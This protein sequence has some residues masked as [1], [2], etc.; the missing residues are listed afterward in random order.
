MSTAHH[1]Q[2]GSMP[3][4]V[5]ILLVL[6]IA[7]LLTV[8]L[9]AFGQSNSAVQTPDEGERVFNQVCATCHQL[10]PPASMEDG[11]PIAPPM[12]MILRHYQMAFDSTSAMEVA[13]TSWLEKPDAE[14]SVLPAH[15]VEEHGLMPPLTITETERQAVVGYLMKMSEDL[16]SEGMGGKMNHDM[17]GMQNGQGK[18]N[19]DMNGMQNGQ[20][21]MNHK[22]MD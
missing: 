4:V 8:L 20:G 15:A 16:G 17:N 5:R 2:N 12:K 3:G 7:F 14:R 13:L 19:H 18:M 22:K 21:K 9:S 6:A 10:D 11:K 1:T